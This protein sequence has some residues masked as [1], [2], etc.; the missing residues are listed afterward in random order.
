MQLAQRLAG[1]DAELLHEPRAGGVE[2]LQRFGLSSG[3]I[4]RQHLQL[5]QALLEGM[6]DDQRLQLAQQLA[7]AAQLEVKLDPLDRRGQALLLQPRPLAIKQLVRAHS[8]ERRSAPHTERLLDRR[9]R[10]L[11]PTGRSVPPRPAE[12]RLPAV[13]IARAGTQLQN[14]AAR[15]TDQPLCIAAR[16]RQRLAQPRDVHLQA[17]HAPAPEDP[18]PTAHRSAARC[19]PRD[20]GSAPAPP[21]AREA[22]DRRA[23]PGGH[24][25]TPRPDRAA[26]PETHRCCPRRPIAS[27]VAVTRLYAYRMPARW[28]APLATS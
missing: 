2:G 4:Q 12:R 11:Q 5:H 10:G 18:R 20:P 17:A 26:R 16:L 6:R 19:P 8:R 15:S 7:V 23:R 25:P 21:A 1:L 13:D 22:A 9:P 14:V 27:F 28:C 3:S 24:R